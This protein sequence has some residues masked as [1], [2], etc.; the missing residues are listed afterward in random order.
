[1]NA[2]RGRSKRLKRDKVLSLLGICRK[3]GKIAAGEYQTE[4]AVR[5]GKVYL[6]ILSKDASANTEKKFRSLCDYYHTSLIQYGEK[7]ELG[8]AVG[9][10]MRASLAVLDAGL[11]ASIRR[12]TAD[13]PK[14]TSSG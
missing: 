2:Y 7:E 11:A 12:Q 4:Q 13:P 9:C 8:N 5:S 14:E 6:V 10:E 1:M 3:A